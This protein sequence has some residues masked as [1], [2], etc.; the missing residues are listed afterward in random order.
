MFCMNPVF[1]SIYADLLTRQLGG[2]TSK[3]CLFNA[4]TIPEKE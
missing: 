2:L 1:D 4:L 3:K